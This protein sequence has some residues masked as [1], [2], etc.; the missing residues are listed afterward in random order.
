MENWMTISEAAEYLGLSK[1]VISLWVRKNKV[2]SIRILGGFYRLWKPEIETIKTAIE[3]AG[4]KMTFDE[5]QK[6]FKLNAKSG[7]DAIIQ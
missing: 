5:N 6:V 1:Q 7:N 4:R 2:R 3:D